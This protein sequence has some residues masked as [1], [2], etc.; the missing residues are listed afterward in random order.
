MPPR[1]P[2]GS[3][4]AVPEGSATSNV[5]EMASCMQFTKSRVS[6][7]VSTEGENCSDWMRGTRCMSSVRYYACIRAT[8]SAWNPG[9]AEALEVSSYHHT[10]GGRRWVPEPEGYARQGLGLWWCP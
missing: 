7:I 2:S 1:D 9:G 3:K 5:P 8:K 6:A 4:A 10:G